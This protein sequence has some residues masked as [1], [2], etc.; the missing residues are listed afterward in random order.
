MK[1]SLFILAIIAFHNLNSNAQES[2]KTSFQQG[3]PTIAVAKPY[4]NGMESKSETVA[5]MIRLEL[6][7]MQQYKVYDE[8]DMTDVL[9]TREDFR[10]DCFGQ[11]CLLQL[12]EALNTDFVMC[13]SIDGLSNRIAVT[14]KIVDVKGKTIYKTMVKEFDDQEF[15]LQR[16]L[17]IVLKQMHDSQMPKEIIDRLEYKNEPIT[18][19]N[20]GRINNSGPRIGGAYLTGSLS[21][22]AQRDENE[23]GLGIQPYVSMIGYQFEKQYVGTENFSALLEGIINISGLEQG[24]FIPTFT[25]MNGFRFGKA[26]WEVAFGPGFGFKKTSNGFFDSE[27]NFSTTGRYFTESEWNDYANQTYSNDPQYVQDGKFIAPTPGDINPNYRFAKHG[28]A[29]GTAYLN[30]TFVFAVGRTFHA[31]ALNI[32]VNAFYSAQ[33]GG[34][35]VGLNIG[36]NV[37]KSKLP[38]H[39]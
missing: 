25:I 21:E 35:M 9:K 20:V 15:E 14:I 16:M 30:T 10:T 28:D 39:R 12:G 7:K 11:N 23:G 29:R 19:N 37:Q 34:G 24:Q 26:G 17:E 5:K 36:F 31:G 1:K 18:T 32:P 33:K 27:K 22:F 2:P 6:I 13:G 3:L 4:V 38:I 8:F